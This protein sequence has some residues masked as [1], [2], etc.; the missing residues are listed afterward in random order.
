M[1]EVLQ[2]Q[3]GAGEGSNGGVRKHCRAFNARNEPCS[4]WVM[5]GKDYCWVHEPSNKEAS[6]AARKLGG[7][8]NR[9]KH[10]P[11]VN[12]GHIPD[13]VRTIEDL[14]GLLDYCKDELLMLNNGL[15]RNKAIV[16]LASTY[17]QILKEGELQDRLGDVEDEIHDLLKKAKDPRRYR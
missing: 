3:E 4:A 2:L 12:A 9:A 17:A 10:S 14:L 1:D 6:D 7:Q 15:N 16:Q 11:R 8:T 5:K 13:K